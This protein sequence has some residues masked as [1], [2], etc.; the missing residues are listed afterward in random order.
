VLRPNFKRP[1]SQFVKKQ[2]KPFQAVIEDKVNQV[3]EAPEIGELKTGDLAGIRVHKFRYNRQEY[4][5]AYYVPDVAP[6]Q[7]D[8]V[9]DS[10]ETRTP[11]F[12][13]IDFY[14]IGSHEN[15]YDDLKMY[16]KAEGWYK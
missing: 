4:L 15:F 2:P 14:K 6:H 3:C 13:W 5:M 11:H 16:L 1:F 9:E 10:P 12:L 7:D 8:D